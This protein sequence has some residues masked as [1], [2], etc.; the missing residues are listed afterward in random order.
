VVD[1]GHH[2]A[3]EL[4]VGEGALGVGA[5]IGEGEPVVAVA[6]DDQLAPLR[7]HPHHGAVGELAHG[8]DAHPAQSFSLT[9]GTP[10]LACTT[11]STYC[12]TFGSVTRLVTS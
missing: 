6:R 1:A 11:R 3:V 9:P 7:H 12:D 8:A 2:A 4:A 10:S 5:A